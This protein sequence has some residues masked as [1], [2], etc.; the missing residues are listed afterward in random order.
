MSDKILLIENLLDKVDK[1]II[2]GGMAFTFQKVLKDM[3]IGGSLYDEAGAKIVPEI[4]AKAEAK[5]V[6]IVLPVDFVTSSEFGE[7]GEISTATLEAGIPDGMMGLDCG[8]ETIKL[9]TATIQS[10]KT[11]IWNGPMGVF[12]MES[13]AAGT[14][15]MM[16][17]IVKVTEQGATTVIGGGDTATACKVYN[18]EDK[19][20]HVSTGGGASLE[21]LEG[22]VLPGIAA[23][24]EKTAEKV[25]ASVAMFAT[26]GMCC[27]D[28]PH[29][30]K[31]SWWVHVPA[32][33]CVMLRSNAREGAAGF[34]VLQ[35]AIP[36]HITLFQARLWTSSRSPMWT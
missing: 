18:T 1:M 6:E 24:S 25:P 11:I 9:N 13:F 32:P 27:L 7:G 3:A 8:P 34:R 17:E 15:T 26:T 12:E 29:E 2:G 20:S 28:Y 14:K 22:K 33:A 30:C 10:A 36:A 23:L 31:C 4:M 5:G 21:L 19:V 16:D 35:V